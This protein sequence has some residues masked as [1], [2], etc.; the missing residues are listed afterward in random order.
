MYICSVWGESPVSFGLYIYIHVSFL[1]HKA[2]RKACRTGIREG[3]RRWAAHIISAWFCAKETLETG[4]AKAFGQGCAKAFAEAFAKGIFIYFHM[5]IYIYVYL[6][7]LGG[8]G[9]GEQV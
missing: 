5:Y 8:G 2:I 3:I 9:M 6:C 7:Y 4:F 1:S